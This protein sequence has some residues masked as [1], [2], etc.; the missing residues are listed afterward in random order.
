MPRLHLVRHGRAAAGWDADP[1]PGLDEVGT[2]QA[3]A[4]A[5][6]LRTVGPLPILCSPLRRTRETAA[7]LA[8]AWGV[9]PVLEPRISEIPS[10]TEDL[11]ERGAWLQ[12]ALAGSWADL[13]PPYRA[14][15]DRYLA[16]LLD[17]VEDTVVVTHFVGINAVLGAAWG[18]DRLVVRTVANTSVTVVDAA[19]GRFEVL[20]EPS[21]ATT[22]VW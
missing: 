4:A 17:L 20:E 1:D 19:S 21:E 13:D 14:Y 6:R 22:E 16:T 10:P 3:A 2:A 7:P 15:R 8:A 11:L 18:D 5:E 9:E 12:Q